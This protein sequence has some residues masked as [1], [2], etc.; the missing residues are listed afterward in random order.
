[1]GMGQKEYAICIP[2][3]DSECE[4]QFS[5]IDSS[6]P[7]DIITGEELNEITAQYTR[8]NIVAYIQA[9]LEIQHRFAQEGIEIS[10]DQ[11]FLYQSQLSVLNSHL[12]DIPDGTAVIHRNGKT[13]SSPW[14]E[15]VEIG[16]EE[17][18]RF[19]VHIDATDNRYLLDIFSNQY[20]RH[21]VEQ[22]SFMQIPYIRERC[23]ESAYQ[24]YE[25]RAFGEVGGYEDLRTMAQQ[26]LFPASFACIP[27][28]SR[29]PLLSLFLS[30]QQ[31]SVV[32][33]LPFQRY[34]ESRLSTGCHTVAEP[35]Y[36][37]LL[38][39]LALEALNLLQ[40]DAE[41]NSVWWADVVDKVE[42]KPVC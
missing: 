17:E 5:L 21:H 30:S 40:V 7:I 2:Y 35:Y 16:V 34:A 10:P 22:V 31:P 4:K 18:N 12:E 29:H 26:G 42:K 15:L 1:M 28:I 24:S 9:A 25:A 11:L 13:V 8:G 41:I 37:E 3:V 23:L 27:P 39:E 32:P 19:E 14:L 20:G 33:F 36:R 38:P 6:S